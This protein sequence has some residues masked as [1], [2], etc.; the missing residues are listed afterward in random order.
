[1]L[2]F[3]AP[4]EGVLHFI[5]C[6]S[7]SHCRVSTVGSGSLQKLFFRGLSRDGFR[8]GPELQSS[9]QSIF[10][11]FSNPKPT[12]NLNIKLTLSETLMLKAFKQA[13]KSSTGTMQCSLKLAGRPALRWDIFKRAMNSSFLKVSIFLTSSRPIGALFSLKI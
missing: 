7:M 9:P 5:L 10:H 3:Q 13:L 6:C 12:V 11:T 4:P 1:M 2:R 8:S